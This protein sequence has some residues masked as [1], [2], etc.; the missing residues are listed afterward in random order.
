MFMNIYEFIYIYIWRE[1]RRDGQTDT[2][3]HI[4]CKRKGERKRESLIP[5]Y[6]AKYPILDG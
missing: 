6:P 2:C 1:D 3:T 4:H 5:Y